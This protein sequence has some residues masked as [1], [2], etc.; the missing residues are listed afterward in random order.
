M[1]GAIQPIKAHSI[2]D[3]FFSN[4][5]WNTDISEEFRP[6]IHSKWSRDID[7]LMLD[8]NSEVPTEGQTVKTSKVWS[9]TNG[10]QTEK[11]VTSKKQI[12]NGKA[13]EEI[14]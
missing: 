4:R 7:R 12:K 9:N 6:I 10:Q 3:D 11:T 1:F 13:E 8:E 14:T 5:L 2:F